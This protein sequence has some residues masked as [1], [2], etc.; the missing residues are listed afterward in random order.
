MFISADFIALFIEMCIK[1]VFKEPRFSN[2]SLESKL[3]FKIWLHFP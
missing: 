1:L 2:Q 3:I